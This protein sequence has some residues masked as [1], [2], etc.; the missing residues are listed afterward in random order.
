[1]GKLEILKNP[2][3][4]KYTQLST[5][6]DSEYGVLWTV[7]DPEGI[8]CMTEELLS[9]LSH[10]QN[11]IEHSGGMIQIGAKV[12]PIRYV[13]AASATPNAF[14]LGGHL[15]LFIRLIKEKNRQA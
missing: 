14:N 8:P 13:V 1:M 2:L 15:E 4:T 10:H 5:R 9:E 3:E 12:Y 6:F 7:M 11:S